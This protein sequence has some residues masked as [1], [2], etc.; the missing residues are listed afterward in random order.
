VIRLGRFRIYTGD[1]LWGWR[2]V[3]IGWGSL[4][5]CGISV[6]PPAPPRGPHKVPPKP[7]PRAGNIPP[8]RFP[9]E[10]PFRNPSGPAE[11]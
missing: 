6:N 10:P 8:A 1:R 11:D 5:F 2:L 3:G 4:W 7:R 9:Q